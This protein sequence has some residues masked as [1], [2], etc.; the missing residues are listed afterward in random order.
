MRSC[1]VAGHDQLF[2]IDVEFSAV[3]TQKTDRFLDVLKADR[4]DVVAVDGVFNVSDRD[5]VIGIK[6]QFCQSDG[7]GR[8]APSAA[9]QPDQQWCRRILFVII[10]RDD[11]VDLQ[12]MIIPSP[13]G[14]P[15]CVDDIVINQC[16]RPFFFSFQMVQHRSSD[17]LKL[18]C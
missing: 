15:V 12:R 3:G 16:A 17:R 13:A 6:A 4:P 18:M 11:Q 1:R 9:F 14:D 8:V 10:V 2:R 7:R 5:P